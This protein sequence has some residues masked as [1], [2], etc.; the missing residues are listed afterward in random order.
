MLGAAWLGAVHAQARPDSAPLSA[1]DWL[2]DTV[3]RPGLRG[4]QA[5]PLGTGEP[6]VSLPGEIDTITTTTLLERNLDAVG[7]LPPEVTGVDRRLWA[8]SA[9]APL[10][11]LIRAERAGL[12]PVLRDLL[13]VLMLAELD[14]PMDADGRGAFLLARIDKLLE[15]GAIEAA[16]ALV[17][18]AGKPTP[19]LFRRAFDIALLMGTENDACAVQRAAPSIAPTFPARIFCLARGGDWP[20]AALSLRTGAAL[21]QLTPDEVALLERFIEPEAYEEA[22]ALPLPTRVTPLVLRIHEAIGEAIPA[23]SLPLAFAHG[24]LTPATGWKAR[25]AAA[26]RLARA[27]AITPSQLFAL[28]VERGA[29]ASGGVWARVRAVQAFETALAAGDTARISATLVALWPLMA[30]AELEM[31]LAEL[32]AASVA[33]LDLTPEASALAYR[34]A[35]LSHDP[36]QA[37]LDHRPVDVMETYLAGIARGSVGG[38]VPPDGLA[39]VIARAFGPHPEQVVL[40]RDL[41]LLLDEGRQGE[42]LLQAMDLLTRG[43][44]GDLRGVDEGLVVMRRLGFE[45]VA[46]KAALQLML[47]ERRG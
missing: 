33:P 11:G 13:Q 20:A 31:A 7:V 28:Y 16:A 42:A 10:V 23:G 29:A 41:Q 39:R 22:D 35:L 24:D 18:A 36:E 32:H 14:A 25:L 37:A 8:R 17:D 26:E 40:S 46:R 30:E 21:G 6:P 34:M 38:A 5:S 9:T 44:E 12:L 45:I 43:V 3:A 15:M 2:S 4:A 47:L 19:E 1:I 27:G